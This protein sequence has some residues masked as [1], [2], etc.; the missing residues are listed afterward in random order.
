MNQETV[1]SYNRRSIAA[2]VFGVGLLITAGGGTAFATGDGSNDTTMQ[3]AAPAATTPATPHAR[4][5]VRHNTTAQAVTPST[6]SASPNNPSQT[7]A[8]GGSASAK[9][10]AGLAPPVPGAPSAGSPNGGGSSK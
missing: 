6:M 8:S 2:A 9:G 3:P 10:T 1:M 4:R 5:V 7:S